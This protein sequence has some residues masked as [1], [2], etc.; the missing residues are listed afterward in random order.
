MG[1]CNFR[2]SKFPII[3]NFS[4]LAFYGLYLVVYL[5]Y[6][7]PVYAAPEFKRLSPFQRSF[8]GSRCSDH[9]AMLSVFSAWDDTRQRGEQA[10]INFCDYKQLSMPTLRVTWEAKVRSNA[11]NI[12]Q[13]HLSKQYNVTTSNNICK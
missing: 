13:T 5:Y 2:I 11:C 6:C 12:T 8:G 1:H 7:H 4:Y 9:I 3:Y 10:E